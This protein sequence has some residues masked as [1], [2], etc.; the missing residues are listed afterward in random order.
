MPHLL[1]ASPHR[2][3]DLARLWY[4]FVSRD[5]AP[6]FQRV[7]L[8]VQVLIYCDANA[9]AFN[10]AWFPGVRLQAP[11]QAARDFVEFYDAALSQARDYL[12]FLDAD[13]FVLD[14]GWVASYLAAFEDPRIA[15]V[16]FLRRSE[17]P[18]VYALLCR[19]DAYRDIP[20]PVFAATCE[21]LQRWPRYINRQ[22]GEYAAIRLRKAGKKIVDADPTGT[23]TLLSDFHGTTVIRASR[24]MFAAAIGENQFESLISSKRY[25]AMGAYDNALIGGL[26]TAIFGEPFATGG[27][28]QALAGSVT[29]ESLRRVLSE[30]QDR[31][32][33][34]YLAGYFKR[35]N[36]AASLLAA[37]EGIE[38]TIPPVVPRSW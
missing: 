28:Q 33:R 38:L 13:L 12:F 3:P 18:G 8:E 35:S 24:E 14:G 29:V 27:T 23:E 5:L 20:P 2:Y 4:R 9:S 32:T 31:A 30:V 7:G 25:F 17:L 19:A 37:K 21:G 36:R 16:C 10:P 22:P 1:L 6:A 34:K 26:Y 15:A 11:D